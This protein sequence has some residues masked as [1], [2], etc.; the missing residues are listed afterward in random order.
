M[1]NEEFIHSYYYGAGNGRTGNLSI[2]NGCL[3]SYERVIVS[4]K[5]DYY[6]LD[7]GNYSVTTS[8]HQ[9]IARSA[10]P[11]RGISV[12]RSLKPK[13]NLN[14][15]L[16]DITLLIRK[17]ARAKKRDY[18]SEIAKS[19]SDLNIYIGLFKLRRSVTKLAKEL[20]AGCDFKRQL[21]LANLIDDEDIKQAKIDAKKAA[22]AK[23]ER[24][25]RVYDTWLGYADDF[26]NYKKLTIYMQGKPYD[27]IRLSQDDPSQ[28]ETS[29][30]I[31]VSFKQARL[32]LKKVLKGDTEY[33]K[34][35][36]I[37]GLYRVGNITATHVKV[38]CHNFLLEQL[39][40]V[41][42]QEVVCENHLLQRLT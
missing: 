10:C 36:Q 4:K 38:G 31:T 34:D 11:G 5:G 30:G 13:A 17:Q 8:S 42:L 22:E 29:Q 1:T 27:L 23:L 35:H 9:T 25:K 16:K 20:L 18:T 6:L 33:L 15:L 26:S 32:F 37:S 41:L 14:K 40:D 7:K 12:Y 2:N 21:E 24:D 3:Y 19:I 28:I 39:K